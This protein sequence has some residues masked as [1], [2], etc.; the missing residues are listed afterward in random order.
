MFLW[1]KRQSRKPK[2]QTKGALTYYHGGVDGLSIGDII[3]PRNDISKWQGISV[4]WQGIPADELGDSGD[5][6][7]ITTDIEIAKGYAG[8]YMSPSGAHVPGRVY[9]VTPLCAPEPDPDWNGS[10]PAIARCARGAEIVAVLDQMPVQTNPSVLVK[11]LADYYTYTATGAP[12]YDADGYVIF[13]PELAQ[14][15]RTR[16]SLKALGKWPRKDRF[17]Y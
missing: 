8:E 4:E 1:K 2:S 5:T 10:F 14:L 9:E 7:S 12:V 11:A 6:V 17:I 15:G 13:T 3:I 16:A